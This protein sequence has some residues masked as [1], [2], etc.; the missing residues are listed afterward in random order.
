[1]LKTIFTVF[2]FSFITLC[3]TA[4]K[5]ESFTA[6]LQPKDGANS[7]LSISHKKVYTPEEAKSNKAATDLALVITNSNNRQ[8]MEWYNLSGK[9]DKIPTELRGTAV[10]I[11]GLGFDKDQFEKCNTA[12]DL[13]RMAGYITNT[14]FAHYGSITDD[15]DAGVKYHCFLILLENGKRAVLWLEAV[16]ANNY[17]VTVKM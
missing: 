9:D 2:L 7:Y 3:A 5:L 8:V 13:Q 4:Q 16:D 1:M 14:S 11:S 15:L 10:G 6:T 17:K 12:Q